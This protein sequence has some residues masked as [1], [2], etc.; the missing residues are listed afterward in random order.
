VLAALVAAVALT[1]APQAA[2]RQAA[3]QLV[4]SGLPPLTYVTAPRSEP[5]RLYVVEQQGVV[6]VLVDGKPRAKP[7]LDI[8]GQVSSGGE[9]GL[10]SIAFHP[11]YAKN[12]KL[13][14][15]YTDV[16]GDTRV[17]EYRSNGT[18]ALPGSARVVMREPQPYP[19]H[20]GGQLQFGPDGLLYIGLGDGG[21]GGDPNNNGQTTTNKLAKIW[22]LDVDRRNAQPE[23]VALGLRNPWRF[24]FDRANGD[25][26]IA[27]V[28]QSAWEEIDYVARADLGELRNFGWA[29]YEGN[30]PYDPSRDLGE[31]ALTAPVE[32]YSH[33]LGCSVTGGYVY[34]GAGRPD[35]AGRYFYGDYCSGRVWS[36]RIQSG[37]AVDQR[38]EPFTID[39][40]SS[41]GEDARGGL[42]AVTSNGSVYRIAA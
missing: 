14:V 37:T 42:Y 10:L 32:V 29:V 22:R 39:A 41:F 25:L 11:D 1:A 19:N 17:V 3:P 5:R 6:R 7:F 16:N 24:S 15:D 9:R 30:A 36:L 18:V 40:L 38:Q 23:L 20:N 34:R 4:V 26:W 13:Y 27:D 28:G 2:P 21:S 12:R 33:Q 31:G 35:L 8:R